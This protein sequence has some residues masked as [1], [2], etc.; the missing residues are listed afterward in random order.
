VQAVRPMICRASA[1]FSAVPLMCTWRTP[2]S[3]PSD[4][5]LVGSMQL[6]SVGCREELKA[7]MSSAPRRGIWHRGASVEAGRRAHQPCPAFSMRGDLPPASGL[8]RVS[9]Q[10][11]SFEKTSGGR[12]HQRVR[13]PWTTIGMAWGARASPGRWR[14]A[15]ARVASAGRPWRRRPPRPR[16]LA[17]GRGGA[18][19][20]CRPPQTWPPLADRRRPRGTQVGDR[21][22]CRWT[23]APIPR[24]VQLRPLPYASP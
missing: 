21:A 6:D 22:C 10:A 1:S 16:R 7:R 14:P 12:I 19:P 18:H 3:D 20:V 9:K 2:F 4:P 5:D 24:C 11:S 15:T 23:L 8:Q 17:S 13:A